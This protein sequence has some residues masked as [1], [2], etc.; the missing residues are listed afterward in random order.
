MG[1]GNRSHRS[2][3]LVYVAAELPSLQGVCG[4]LS[5]RCYGREVARLGA[6][7]LVELSVS[8]LVHAVNGTLDGAVLPRRSRVLRCSTASS[9]AMTLAHSVERVLE[10]VWC[11]GEPWDSALGS[12]TACSP[13][14]TVG[15]YMSHMSHASERAS[16]DHNFLPRMILSVKVG[17]AEVRTRR[18][19]RPV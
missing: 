15:V 16:I 12:L 1:H 14:V 9:R 3:A 19:C 17:L 2:S 4:W 13:S 8:M 10:L 7:Q 6:W 11:A 18:R 5:T